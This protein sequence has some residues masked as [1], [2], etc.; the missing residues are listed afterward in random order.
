MSAD[1]PERH[2]RAVEALRAGGPVAPESLH[3]R[4]AALELAAAPVMTRRPV[5]RRT[6]RAWR[7][8]AVAAVASVAALA[9]AIGLTS[10]GGG[11]DVATVAAFSERAATEPTPAPD[12]SQPALLRRE[13]EQVAFPNWSEKFGWHADGARSETIDGRRADT[14]FYTHEGHR[15]SY[16]VISGE[17]IDPPA[18]AVPLRARGVQLHRFRDGEHR[19]VVMF[20]RDGRTCVLA[21]H[22]LHTETLIKLASWQGDGAVQF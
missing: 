4:L 19:D 13:F 6:P 22:V 16:T 20:T 17:P 2:R 15:I 5:Q 10:V 14:V 21:G 12:P 3:R 1:V 11:P 8:A 18:D 9:F 7:L